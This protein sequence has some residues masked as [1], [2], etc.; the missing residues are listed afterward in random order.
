MLEE[1][2][3]G[4][5]CDRG[6][7]RK[8]EQLVAPAGTV[9]L[10]DCR[11]WHRQHANLSR[12]SRSCLLTIFTPRWVLPAHGDQTGMRDAMLSAPGVT[13]RE[14][15]RLIHLLGDQNADVE[16]WPVVRPILP[17]AHG[18]SAGNGSIAP[19]QE[20]LPETSACRQAS[21]L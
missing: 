9:I 7:D 15:E 20:E 11:T 5:P 6:A 21:K 16:N 18:A 19:D 17:D 14:T 3:A 1:V 8:A 10:Y 2:P 4:G 13:A 12:Q